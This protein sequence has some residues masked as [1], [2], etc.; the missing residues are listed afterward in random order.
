MTGKYWRSVSAALLT[1][2]LLAGCSGED[3]AALVPESGSAA[4]TPPP[5]VTNPDTP[6]PSPPTTPPVTTPPVTTPPVTT[7]PGGETPPPVAKN[8]AP[9]ISGTPA[10]SAAIGSTY[11]FAPGASDADGDVLSWSI[12]GMPADASFSA[13]TGQ[14]SWTPGAAGTW[15][16][17]VITVTDAQGATA[18]LPPFSI[19]VASPAA[20]GVATLNWTAPT[21]FT[22]GSALPATEP[23]SYRIYHGETESELTSVAEVDSLASTLT[24]KDLA[25]GTHYFAVAAISSTG[26]DGE[27]SRILSKTVM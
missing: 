26:E 24:L 12:S 7:P 11:Q 14:L 10:A 8:T 23:A 18:S 16:N 9:T 2:A 4:T 3:N 5:V 21:E 25:P 19:T 13:S 6:A 20:K 22:D 1:G 17:I 15:S 27:R